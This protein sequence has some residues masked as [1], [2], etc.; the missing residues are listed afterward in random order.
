MNLVPT[1]LSI[2]PL[3]ASPHKIM[4]ESANN[5]P[6]PQTARSLL[7]SLQQSFPVIRDSQPLA[8]GIDKQVIA[9]QPDI[10]R[11][12]LRTALGIHTKSLNYLKSL[13]SA[14]SRFNL[15]GSTAGEVSEE[16][17][18]L[19]A[20]TLRAHFKKQADDRKAKQAAE[21][22]LVAERERQEKLNQLAKKFSR[23]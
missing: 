9:Q 4:T 23:E 8:I 18:T 12:L 17:R 10:N 14:S 2:D 21:A 13:Q 11:K 6:A 3:N 19:A 1:A 20:Q 15:D 22:A 16:Q 5:T 7:K